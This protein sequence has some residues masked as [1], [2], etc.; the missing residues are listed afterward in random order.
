MHVKPIN[1]QSVNS[2]GIARALVPCKSLEERKN[3]QNAWFF[4]LAAE[5]QNCVD[6]GWKIGFITLTYD[7]EHLPYLPSSVFAEGQPFE[8]I[9]CFD[10][11]HLRTLIKGLRKWFY[12]TYKITSCKYLFASE[13]GEHTQRSHYHGLISWPTYTE[14][15]NSETGELVRKRVHVSASDVHAA[16]KKFW[17]IPHKVL[18]EKTHL[19]RVEYEPLGFVFPRDPR[20]GRDS[21][22]YLHKP[23]ELEANPVAAARYA[24]KYVCKDFVWL[25]SL[26]GKKLLTKSKGFRDRQCFHIQSR[27]LGIC[28]LEG[29]T[30]EDKLK[31]IRDGVWLAGHDKPIDIP[32]YIRNKILFNPY[33]I[34]DEQ[35]N[36][37]VRRT[38]TKFFIDHYEEI[39]K[40]KVDT[41]EKLFVKMMD[42]NWWRN[43]IKN[44]H[45]F[46][47]Q[48]KND[49]LNINF[50]NN[51]FMH[52]MEFLD[53]YSFTPRQLASKY[54]SRFGLSADCVCNVDD[55]FQWLSRYIE[56]NILAG[57]PRSDG[58][59]HIEW[60]RRLE[61]ILSATRFFSDLDEQ[62]E[63]E[64]NNKIQDYWK[65][66]A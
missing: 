63:I 19:M 2:N 46:D 9:Q 13:L 25:N 18:D 47:W 55:S 43:S 28:A 15:E 5:M 36:R 21:H 35:G 60:N 31:M 17:S 59:S 48:K 38:C 53:D 23:F 11:S 24:A 44:P 12:D 41:M 52:Y 4:R 10:K 49:P 1:I 57:L 33:Y 64:F 32:I 56:D 7:D 40:K 3:Y 62:N 16:I 14:E 42:V 6:K 20:G 29:A 22:G 51:A 45:Q 50:A 39:F 8:P 34:V 66:T 30:D 58:D 37:L 54:L 26:K 65:S 61:R 27:S